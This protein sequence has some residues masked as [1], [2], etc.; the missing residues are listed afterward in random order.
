MPLTDREIQAAT[1]ALFAARR[2]HQSLVEEEQNSPRGFWRIID[3]INR[4]YN[5]VMGGVV[6]TMLGNDPGQG[7]YK[8][9]TGQETYGMYDLLVG[10]G[11]DPESNATKWTGVGLDILPGAFLDPLTY[12]SFGTSNIGKATKAAAKGG[13]MT[14]EALAA[15]GLWSPINAYIPFTDISTPLLPKHAAVPVARQFD[16]AG[17]WLKE[18]MVGQWAEKVFRTERSILSKD[19]YQ[20]FGD[21]LREASGDR[22]ISQENVL[23]ALKMLHRKYP[24][25]VQR[26]ATLYLENPDAFKG[27]KYL[28]RIPVVFDDIKRRK[29]QA[30]LR[31]HLE[32]DTNYKDE[33]R[34]A[35]LKEV[36]PFRHAVYQLADLS[37]RWQVEDF[38]DIA[39][40]FTNMEDFGAE[41]VAGA[42]TEMGDSG[43]GTIQSAISRHIAGSPRYGNVKLDP[44]EIEFYIIPEAELARVGELTRTSRGP[45]IQLNKKKREL[46]NVATLIAQRQA[47]HGTADAQR[48]GLLMRQAKLKREVQDLEFR[49][50]K[51]AGVVRK[52]TPQEEMREY[53]AFAEKQR[54]QGFSTTVEGG[55]VG[56]TAKVIFKTPALADDIE[57]IHRGAALKA[58]DKISAYLEAGN[59]D[60]DELIDA[61]VLNEPAK[62]RKLA[63][64]IGLDPNLA[65]T[66]QI[67]ESLYHRIA[68]KRMQPGRYTK[69]VEEYADLLM[70]DVVIENPAARWVWMQTKMKVLKQEYVNE[71]K[72]IEAGTWTPPVN[73]PQKILYDYEIEHA[74]QVADEHFLDKQRLLVAYE[75]AIASG[76]EVYSEEVLAQMRTK[77]DSLRNYING[78]EATYGPGGPRA[79]GVR[80]DVGVASEEFKKRFPESQG[81]FLRWDKDGLL[82]GSFLPPSRKWVDGDPIDEILPGTSAI[83]PFAGLSRYD[84][85]GFYEGVPY[86]VTGRA[87]G[88]G[89][90]AGEVLLENAQV[91]QNLYR[92]SGGQ[93]IPEISQ[94]AKLRNQI[95]QYETAMGKILDSSSASWDEQANMWVGGTEEEIAELTELDQFVLGMEDELSRETQQIQEALGPALDEVAKLRREKLVTWIDQLEEMRKTGD[96]LERTAYV[97]EQVRQRAMPAIGPDLEVREVEKATVKFSPE[98]EA[99]LEDLRPLR[100]GTQD[101]YSVLNDYDPDFEMP[102]D[103]YVHHMLEDTGMWP[104]SKAKKAHKKVLKRVDELRKNMI[105]DLR[106]KGYQDADQIMNIVEREISLLVPEYARISKTTA[107]GR[108][109]A[110]MQR[111]YP[112]T[113]HEINASD[114]PFKFETL[115]PKIANE[116]FRT[117]SNWRYG[118][119][120]YKKAVEV[121]GMYNPSRDMVKELGLVKV[122]YHLPF[123]N[124]DK[125][126]FKDVWIPKEL[127]DVIKGRLMRTGRLFTSDE[128]FQAVLNVMHYIRN[129]WSAWTLG[130]FPAFHARNVVSDMMLA[131]QAG[132]NPL[133]PSGMRAYKASVELLMQNKTNVKTSGL[134][135]RKVNKMLKAAFPEYNQDELYTRMKQD[136]IVDQQWIRDID[137]YQELRSDLEGIPSSK[138]IFE[139]IA[140][141]M[142]LTSPR[143]SKALAVGAGVGRHTQNFTH[144]ALFLNQLERYAALKQAGKMQLN[145]KEAA[146]AAARTVHKHLFDYADLSPT[147]HNLKIMIP[148]WTWSRKNIPRQLEQF[149]QDPGSFGKYYRAYHGAWNGYEK[150]FEALDAPEYLQTQLGIPV[151]KR[152]AD[153]GTETYSVFSPMG[154]V[155]MTEL[156]EVA[157]ALR[158]DLGT[159]V[160]SRVGPWFKE[161]FE[162]ILNY[163]FFTQRAIDD[164]E[165]RDL[166]GVPVHPRFAHLIRNIRLVTEFDRLNPA[167]TWTKIGQKA[168]FWTSDR[169]HRDEPNELARWMRF[170]TGVN[171][172]DVEPIE[173]VQNQVLRA[174]SE[175]RDRMTRARRAYARGQKQEA[176]RLMYTAE[177]FAAEY[178]E[179]NQRLRELRRNKAINLSERNK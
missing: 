39:G 84:K 86:V 101:L 70:E 153:D 58:L 72:A 110:F 167:G 56:G 117:A 36:E 12:V 151:R 3:Y 132:L 123:I 162:Q 159:Y 16:K 65:T 20:D 143:R 62:Y 1:D 44:K 139:R 174:G 172:R 52:L 42:L 7:L 82:P 109:G 57:G 74:L 170:G 112:F 41:S 22:D 171:V 100:D 17:A 21:Y 129:Y 135:L 114:L 130:V 118:H 35:A 76:D 75:K 78:M 47:K 49:V 124:P 43:V 142:P 157:G 48:P 155:P 119:D 51:E 176:E 104:W 66:R 37:N 25:Q 60:F 158:G 111:K 121:S 30:K 31:G 68:T 106:L 97:R 34:M 125:N 138:G 96:P 161:A 53:V 6:E 179:A 122:D 19:A 140:E 23:E 166:A 54:G 128:G 133:K 87:L 150:D 173:Q 165:I 26:L 136:R 4:P 61:M 71:L 9:L 147:E 116:E 85:S 80:V 108:F 50:S 33:Y 113:I 13:K 102:I 64:K 178:K 32:A 38:E 105:A 141:W 46:E 127:D 94:T 99:I 73:V 177:K 148:F 154:W 145:F 144:A 149:I 169:P 40:Q 115:I 79:E 164:G 69:A 137:V 95:E 81:L 160:L 24:E 11:A 98:L 146:D 91:V 67:L 89:E 131:E 45:R 15:K 156:A 14:R 63:R 107:G 28:E 120:L 18:T 163:D 126:P 8:G 83:D 2:S 59:T 77:A 92:Q 88:P 5:T 103:N 55:E 175:Y 168:G 152:V 27:Q 90:D 93:S 10:A 29:E 134:S